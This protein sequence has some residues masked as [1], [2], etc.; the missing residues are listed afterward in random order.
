MM[1][2]LPCLWGSCPNFLRPI[3]HTL[4]ASQAPWRGHAPR[5]ISM[6]A[7][8]LVFLC[9]IVTDLHLPAG[10]L[11]CSVD[12]LPLLIPV[13]LLWMQSIPDSIIYGFLFQNPVQSPMPGISDSTRF[14]I[15]YAVYF[16]FLCGYLRRFNFRAS[17]IFQ[18]FLRIICR[19][20][21]QNSID[22]P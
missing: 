14:W 15:H 3:Y 10:V 13:G 5:G 12:A 17:N 20:C 16:R 4:S 19:P 11:I 8:A 21:L 9:L 18:Q 1:M 6:P 7:T 2:N 22:H